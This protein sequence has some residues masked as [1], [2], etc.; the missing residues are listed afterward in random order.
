[1]NISIVIPC[2]QECKSLYS[3]LP[4]L[5][6]VL[7][8]AEIIVVWD[9]P[10]DGTEKLCRALSVRVLHGLG[11]GL[12]AAIMLGI[13]HAKNDRVIIMDGDG[14]H[15]VSAIADIAYRL[16]SYDLIAGKRRDHAGLSFARWCMS[17]A[18]RWLTRPLCPQHDVMTGLFGLDRRII[19]GENINL[20]TWK[21]GLE[22][23]VKGQYNSF[24]EEDYYFQ[25]RIAGTS[26]AGIKPA[27]QFLA[28]VFRLYCWKIDLTQM[29]R[30]CVVGTSG[31]LV[32]LGILTGLVEIFGMDYRPAA[33]LGIGTAMFWNYLWNKFWTFRRKDN[34]IP[35][36]RSAATSESSSDSSAD[37]QRKESA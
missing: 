25:P 16:P 15:P 9:G 23:F 13:V 1:M 37:R 19:D 34:V 12:G 20:N 17:E 2:Y 18:C 32:N 29:M 28:Q 5:W 4:S 8:D 31:L 3:L 7:P 14:Q 6:K 27:I 11:H 30:F 22:I 35:Y 26:K 36:R 10:D 33:V 24:T 21:I